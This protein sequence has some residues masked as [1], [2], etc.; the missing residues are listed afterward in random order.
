[1]RFFDAAYAASDRPV[2]LVDADPELFERLPE[3]AAKASAALSVSTIELRPGRW[4]I[5]SADEERLGLLVLTGV[6]ARTA[7]VGTQSGSELLGAGDV[8]RPWDDE[9][10][11]ASVGFAVRWDVL[12]RAR[13]GVLDDAF[14]A[15]ACRC[16]EVLGALVV[17]GVQRSHR[18]ALQLAIGHLR[19]I[20][21]RLIGLFLHLGDRWG[22]M[23][24]QGIHV[25]LRLTHDVVAQL[26][27]AQRPTVTT[28]LND[29][30]RAGQ[31]VRRSDR[32]WVV[33]HP[34]FSRPSLLS[35]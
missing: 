21:D 4:E 18:L 22:R 14:F 29:L 32:T 24:P 9:A 15:A 11:V 19:H 33:A 6:V 31:L 35:A 3:S 16:P 20:N 8:L 7:T 30:E 26:V 10:V 5:G 27:G 13:L 12:H 1:M 17:R 34:D 25:P 23:T 2:R 28:G